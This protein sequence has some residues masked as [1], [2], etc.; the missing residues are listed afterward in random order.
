[1]RL[2][3]IIIAA[4]I[5][6]SCGSAHKIQYMGDAKTQDNKNVEIMLAE[7]FLPEME[8][9]L[10]PMGKFFIYGSYNNMN[11]VQKKVK[12][13]ASSLGGDL[14]VIYPPQWRELAV[15]RGAYEVVSVFDRLHYYEAYVYKRKGVIEQ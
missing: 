10:N 2:L 3:T 5:S 4:L 6:I 12:R 15:Q 11:Q 13:K 7:W 1:M 8:A 14:V 9:E